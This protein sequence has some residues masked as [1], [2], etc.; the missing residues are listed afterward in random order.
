LEPSASRGDYFVWVGFPYE[1]S[2]VIGV[3]FLDET[4]NSGLQIDQRM[5]HAVPKPAPG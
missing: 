5:E 2:G 4:V 3:V 1:G